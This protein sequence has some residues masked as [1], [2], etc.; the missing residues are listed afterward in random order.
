MPHDQGPS[1]SLIVALV[2]SLNLNK[3]RPCFH[4]RFSGWFVIT[5]VVVTLC[6]VA[7]AI[8]LIMQLYILN[9][10]GTDNQTGTGKHRAP[11]MMVQTSFAIVAICGK[12]IKC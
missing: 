1:F 12:L 10:T 5:Q 9:R 4:S 11:I 3:S 7:Q 6:F 2:S 8:N